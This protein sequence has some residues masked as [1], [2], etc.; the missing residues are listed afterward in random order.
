VE[1]N[2]LKRKLAEGSLALIAGNFESADLVD[3][4]G[5]L[6]LLDAVWIDLEHGATSIDAIPDLTRAADLW[7]MGSIIRV[8]PGDAA[9]ITRVLTLGA[10]GVIVPHVNTKE[11]AEQAVDAA[12]FTPAGHRGVSGGRRSYGRDLAEYFARA[13]EE[14]TVGVMIEEVEG[15]DNLDAILAVPHVDLF[16]VSH[17]DLGQ[18]LGLGPGAAEH[19]KLI[20]VYD[21]AIARIAAAGKAAAAVIPEKDLAR[22]LQLGVRCLKLPTWQSFVAAGAR[23]YL[24]SVEDA[25]A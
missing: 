3:F 16:F 12:K 24:K 18:S 11:A 19:P 7:G 17:Y 13:N 8:P 1:T 5:S 23:R 22:Y 4:A 6:Q 9:T 20:E 10:T 2:R 14:T 25:R 21:S 15:I